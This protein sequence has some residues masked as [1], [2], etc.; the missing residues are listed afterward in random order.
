MA[1]KPKCRKCGGPK[2]WDGSVVDDPLYMRSGVCMDCVLAAYLPKELANLEWSI[3]GG[4]Y[5]D[6]HETGVAILDAP[7]VK[8]CATMMGAKKN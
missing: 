7:S 2:R 3:Q 5:G 4:A 8:I 1:G 6:V